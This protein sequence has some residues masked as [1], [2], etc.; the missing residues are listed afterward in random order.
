MIIKGDIRYKEEL[1]ELWNEVFGDGLSYIELFF[2]KQYSRCETFCLKE[3]EKIVSAFYLLP[4]YLSYKDKTYQGRYLYAAATYEKYRGRKIMSQLIEE[5]E[6]YCK[7]NGLDFIALLPADEGL[8]NY[9]SRFGFHTAMYKYRTLI[10]DKDK[11]THN[12]FK[13]NDSIDFN[14]IE[15]MRASIKGDKLLFYAAELEYII[16]SMK[17]Y[18]CNVYYDSDKFFIYNEDDS[19]IEEYIGNTDVS[20]SDLTDGT[21]MY[22]PTPSVGYAISEKVKF[23]MICPINSNLEECVDIYMNLALD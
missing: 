12:S 6:G 17:S 7:N 8:Y 9:Y 20:L 19:T 14:R 23:G 2:E 22:T 1:I 3:D 5:A 15:E 18:G 16:T 21:V 4:C 10:T 13:N 11:G